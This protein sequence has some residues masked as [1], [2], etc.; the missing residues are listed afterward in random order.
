MRTEEGYDKYEEGRK[1]EISIKEG[2]KVSE[3]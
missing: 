1:S 2:G 3:V